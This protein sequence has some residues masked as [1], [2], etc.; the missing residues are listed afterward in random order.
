MYY[1]SHRRNSEFAGAFVLSVSGKVLLSDAF[2]CN[3][4]NT[5]YTPNAVFQYFF[6][7]K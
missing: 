3:V 1:S 5:K 2:G 4:D 7:A 6:L